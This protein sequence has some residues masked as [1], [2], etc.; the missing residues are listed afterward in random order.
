MTT[1]YIY[2][3][4]PTFRKTIL[5]SI[6]SDEN[7]DWLHPI[8]EIFR[9]R[10]TSALAKK[11]RLYLVPSVFDDEFDPDFAPVATSSEDLPEINAWCMNF[12][13]NVLEVFAGRR[14]P[15]QLTKIFHH[16][17]Y[18]ELLKK[19]GSEKDVGKIRKLHISQPLDGICEAT[20]TVR[21]ADRLRALVFRFEG[22]DNRWL[23]T[24]LNL[25]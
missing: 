18:C 13:L 21:F 24:A 22:I 3:D 20:V 25:L 7:E 23:C 11:S 16:R 2:E 5:N 8:L 12:T 15:T 1:N 9:P 6:S 19:S 10:P 4:V 17:I 14:P